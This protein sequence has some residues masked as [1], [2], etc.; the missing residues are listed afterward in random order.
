MKAVRGRGWTRTITGVVVAYALALQAILLAMATPHHT[1]MLLGGDAASF[2]L[3]HDGSSG[4]QDEPTSPV[5]HAECCIVAAFE[6]PVISPVA[7]PHRPPA[8]SLLP[9]VIRVFH[10]A[11]PSA[12]S[13]GSPLGSRAPPRLA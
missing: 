2:C 6:R 13:L 10:D 9:V 1:S 5:T 4:S 7:L 3:E 11:R 12:T 8:R